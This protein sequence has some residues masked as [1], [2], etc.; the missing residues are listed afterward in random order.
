MHM[1]MRCAH[2]RVSCFACARE[3]VR[4]SVRACACMRACVSV[5]ARDRSAWGSHA[6]GEQHGLCEMV[7]EMHIC[8]DLVQLNR[9]HQLARTQLSGGMWCY[10]WISVDI[11]AASHWSTLAADMREPWCCVLYPRS[12]F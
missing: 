3:S 2:R 8:L 4:E 10:V 11:T 9:D 7:D 12:H 1:H 5:R 6:R